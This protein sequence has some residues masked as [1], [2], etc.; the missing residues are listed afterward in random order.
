MA[1]GVAY[2]S[3]DRKLDGFFETLGV[4][5]NIGL[6]WLA[7]FGRSRL[8]APLAQDAQP[9]GPLGGAAFDPPHR[10]AISRCS[11]FPA[12]TSRKS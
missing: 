2:V 10:R 12:A 1:D 11:I 8:I 3:E 4:S 5:E 9:R 7:K 6:G